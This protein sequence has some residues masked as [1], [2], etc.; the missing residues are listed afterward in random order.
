MNQRVCFVLLIM[1]SL[2]FAVDAAYG[3]VCSHK[4]A[5]K[6]PT[7]SW[8]G[9]VSCEVGDPPQQ[10]HCGQNYAITNNWACDLASPNKCCKSGN[11][12]LIE[13]HQFSCPCTETV[14]NISGPGPTTLACQSN[15]CPD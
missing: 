1:L 6:H 3:V 11:V 2:A 15:E 10:Q 4:E 7:I 14:T 9:N 8:G 5:Q 12:V 13:M